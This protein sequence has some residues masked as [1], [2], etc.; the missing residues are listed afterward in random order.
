MGDRVCWFRCTRRARP[1]GRL[2]GSLMSLFIDTF[3]TRLTR[4]VT[5]TYLKAQESTLPRGAQE[6]ELILPPGP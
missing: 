1:W 2:A 6:L 5:R 3:H 4:M